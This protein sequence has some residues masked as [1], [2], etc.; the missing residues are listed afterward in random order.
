MVMMY[1]CEIVHLI[2]SNEAFSALPKKIENLWFP[3]QI[4]KEWALIVHYPQ[5]MLLMAADTASS[6][7]KG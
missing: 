3:I 6:V 5:Q 4:L 7:K 1:V 2:Q